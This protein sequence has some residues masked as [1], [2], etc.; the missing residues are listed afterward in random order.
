MKMS[1]LPPLTVTHSPQGFADY[2]MSR[3]SVDNKLGDFY[4]LIKLV[5]P[6]CC[7]P[8][9]PPVHHTFHLQVWVISSSHGSS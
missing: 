4:A 3:L 5:R 9:Y 2:L 1:G 7:P 8:V 6:L